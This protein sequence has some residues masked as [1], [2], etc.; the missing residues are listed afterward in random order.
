MIE[1]QN[2]R[3]VYPTGEGIEH[4]SF[5]VAPGEFLTIVGP[6]GAGKTTV[7]R[8]IYLDLWPQEGSVQVAEYNS[9]FMK[10]REIPFV[11]RKLGIVFQDFRLLPD[12]DVFENVAFACQVT[13]RR[14]KE[15]KKRVLRALADVGL[16]HKARKMPNELSGG[17]QQRVSIARAIANEPYVLLADEPTGNLDPQTALEIM[18]VLHRIHIRGTAVIMAT[19]NYEMV[20]NFAE[21][22]IHM[23]NGRMI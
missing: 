5:R 11:R 18:N 22:V 19:H 23:K 20:K 10:K 1:L 4:I 13:G 15:I 3:I 7:L 14:Q 12:R 17:E 21:R 8:A 9:L 2:V 16:S 6:S